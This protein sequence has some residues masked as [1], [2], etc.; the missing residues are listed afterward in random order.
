MDFFVT[1]FSNAYEFLYQGGWPMIP[2]FICSLAGVAV[3]IERFI[4][5]RTGRVINPHVVDVLD[6]FDGPSSIATSHHVCQHAGGAFARIVEEVLNA[7]RVDRA[8]MVETMQA[9]GRREV[10]G[11]ERGL[12]L[13]EI[14][15]NVSPLIG[16]LGTVLGMVT[17]FDAITAEGMGNPQVLS[18]GISKAL[19]TTVAGLCVAIPALSFHSYFTKRVE[20]LAI[21]MQ[22]LVTGFISKLE[23][24]EDPLPQE[25]AGVRPILP[26]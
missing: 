10:G 19:I 15:A 26:R 2:L 24:T 1:K 5:L 18:S 20:T 9:T 6:L 3:I 17:V 7:R 8:H 14:V 21:E 16:L 22:D 25:K 23:M 13:L 12:T 4:A 11:L